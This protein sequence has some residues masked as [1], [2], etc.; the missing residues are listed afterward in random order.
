MLVPTNMADRGRPK[1][2]KAERLAAQYGV[3]FTTAEAKAIEKAAKQAEQ[4]PAAWIRAMAVEAAK[5]LP[6]SRK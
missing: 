6:N 5:N 3:R 4:T 1:K 2:P